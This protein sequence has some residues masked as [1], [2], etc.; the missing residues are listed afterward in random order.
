MK[1]SRQSKRSKRACGRMDRGFTWA[2]ASPG[3]RRL[4]AF[5]SWNQQRKVLR[6]DGRPRRAPLECP[7]AGVTSQTGLWTFPTA[8]HQA[9]KKNPG[10]YKHETSGRHFIEKTRN[11]Q[12]DRLGV[13]GG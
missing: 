3:R 6:R 2:S 10:R 8:P 11:N 5:W 9:K 4:S 12:T 1:Q 13:S 7:P